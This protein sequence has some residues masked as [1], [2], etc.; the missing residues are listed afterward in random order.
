MTSR[1]DP[2]AVLHDVSVERS[3]RRVLD[4]I[5]LTLAA[6]TVTLLV[7]P[8]GA[9]KTTLMHA[10]G[11]GL[12]VAAGT[13]AVD[14]LDPRSARAARRAVG[15]VPQ[16][17]AL[18]PRLT[19]RENLETF[20]AFAG[21]PATPA[22]V[23]DCLARVA[24]TGVAG[25]LVGTL[26][27]GYQRRANIAC[28][29]VTRPLLLLLDEPLVGLDPIARR[30]ICDDLRRLVRRDGVAALMATHDLDEGELIADKVAVL[31]DGTLAAVGR[32]EEL[33]EKLF[34]PGSRR[35]EVALTGVPDEPARRSLAAR[36][37]APDA[38]AT[39]WH[40]L[41]LGLTP[42]GVAD[43]GLAPAQIREMR[44]R[45]LGLTDAYTALLAGAA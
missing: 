25:Q 26:S 16:E 24:L 20:A 35:V 38:A 29:L 37:L 44:V 21:E 40:G 34:P 11:G 17:I 15:L 12:P 3:G 33:L 22:A 18:Y 43:L 27:G 28:A 45:R 14:G 8:N 4:G 19:V 6:G 31:R 13:V 23:E 1:P 2:V 39:V 7:G 36:G 30:A 9:G 5:S 32:P 42:F 10:L 41:S